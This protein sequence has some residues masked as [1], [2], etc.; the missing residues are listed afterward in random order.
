MLASCLVAMI[1][2]IINFCSMERASFL[3]P[4]LKL[5]TGNNPVLVKSERIALFQ[6]LCVGNLQLESQSKAG[7]NSIIQVL[8]K[9]LRINMVASNNIDNSKQD[10]FFC[11][12]R[13][14]RSENSVFPD[15]KKVL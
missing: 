11:T 8:T 15:I 13:V 6:I 1:I 2:K 3:K 14:F 5:R 4:S 10:A 7:G 9:N 12:I